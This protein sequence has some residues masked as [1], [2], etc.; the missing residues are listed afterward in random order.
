MPPV[1]AVDGGPRPKVLIPEK[2]SPDGL[3]LLQ[4]SLHVHEKKGLSPDQLLDIIG[5][6]DAL[7]VRSET[8]VTSA[9]LSAGNRGLHKRRNALP[10]LSQPRNPPRSFL[11]TSHPILGIPFMNSYLS[12]DLCCP[13]KSLSGGVEGSGPGDGLGMQDPG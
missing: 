9:L 3:R 10:N 6:Y 5:D 8:K 12:R 13:C 7:I 2:V 4:A 11:V 1:V